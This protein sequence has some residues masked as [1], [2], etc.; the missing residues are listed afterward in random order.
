MHYSGPKKITDQIYQVGGP[1]MS[2][3]KDG[4]VY[5]LDVGDLALIDSGSGA[6]FER[7]VRNIE[8]FGFDPAKITSIIL[9]HCHVD[10]TGGAHLFR[11]HFGSR[12][13]MHN[14]DA[15]IVERADPRLTAAFCFEIDFQ[16][17]HIDKKLYGE[18]G[19][20][21]CGTQQMVWLHT[22]GHSPGSISLY[23]DIGGE[24]CLFVQD[25][26]S[27]LLKEFDC[28]AVAWVKS[29]DR[30]LG[31]NADMLCDGHSG[32]YHPKKV[33]KEYLQYCI[34]MQTRMGYLDI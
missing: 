14:L 23:L 11:S 33:V 31:V 24:R 6:G 3:G 27:P 7:I 10:H 8:F 4:I 1:T 32:A 22:P 17:L 18:E 20:I 26:A 30:L 19:N 29:V 12:L 28:D 2:N 15:E 34:N 9:T 5:L 21:P 16:P 13:I 25:I